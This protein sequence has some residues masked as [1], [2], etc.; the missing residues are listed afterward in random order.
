MTV[1]TEGGGVDVGELT[2]LLMIFRSRLKSIFKAAPAATSLCNRD[3]QLSS[4][5]RK[6]YLRWIF[7]AVSITHRRRFC[8]SE[9]QRSPGLSVVCSDFHGIT[10]QKATLTL[11]QAA[12][13]EKMQRVHTSEPPLL[14]V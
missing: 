13:H 2:Y 12:C 9:E 11:L 14:L 8:D 5:R 10:G 6:R 3:V 1:L 4:D 7:P